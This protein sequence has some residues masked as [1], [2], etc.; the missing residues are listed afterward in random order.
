MVFITSAIRESKEN[1]PTADGQ[2]VSSPFDHFK[3]PPLDRGEDG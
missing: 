1:E 3:A 2:Q